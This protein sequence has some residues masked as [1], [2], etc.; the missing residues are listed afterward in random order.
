[1]QAGASINARDIDGWTPMHAA[2]H[3]GQE[4]SCRLLAEHMASLSAVDNA[5]SPTTVGL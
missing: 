1:V 3:W 5:V 2:A 4:E